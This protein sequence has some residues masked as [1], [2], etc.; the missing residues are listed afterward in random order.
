[1]AT[2]LSPAFPRRQSLRSA[3]AAHILLAQ[4]GVESSMRFATTAVRVRRQVAVAAHR[5]LRKSKVD[6]LILFLYR[7]VAAMA[8]TGT[9]DPKGLDNVDAYVLSEATAARVSLALPPSSAPPEARSAPPTGAAYRVV[10]AGAGFDRRVDWRALAAGGTSGGEGAP[11]WGGY[12]PDADAANAAWAAGGGIAGGPIMPHGGSWMGVPWVPIPRAPPAA[13]VSGQ[14]GSPVLEGGTKVSPATAYVAYVDSDEDSLDNADAVAMNGVGGITA[15]QAEREAAA[16]GSN[17]PSRWRLRLAPFRRPSFSAFVTYWNSLPL[18]R[19]ARLTSL[20]SVMVA[21]FLFAIALTVLLSTYARSLRKPVVKVSLESA[22]SLELPVI[23]ICSSFRE[24]PAFAAY[25]TDR[26]PGHP[27]FTA[28]AFVHWEDGYQEAYPNTL[29][30]G[31]VEEITTGSAA[32]PFSTCAERLSAMSLKRVLDNYDGFNGLKPLPGV[33]PLA[34][35]RCTACMRIGAGA[36]S[37]LAS[38]GGRMSLSANR[39]AAGLPIGISLSLTTS[40]AFQF[41]VDG[42][43]R[44]SQDTG[45]IFPH[46]LAAMTESILE[47]IDDITAQGILDFGDRDPFERNLEGERKWFSLTYGGFSSDDADFE[48]LVSMHCNVYFFSGY[49]YPLEEGLASVRFKLQDTG[50]ES[51]RPEGRVRWVADNAGSEALKLIKTDGYTT[52]F[53][54]V[55]SIS[56]LAPLPNLPPLPAASGTNTSTT[57]ADGARDTGRDTDRDAGATG[58]SESIEEI[59]ATR[60]NIT[61]A[62]RHQ[63][64]SRSALH[65]NL[66]TQSEAEAAAGPP[67]ADRQVTLVSQEDRYVR[68]ELS[69]LIDFDGSTRYLPMRVSVSELSRS[70]ISVFKSNMF[71]EWLFDI[72]YG[73]FVTTV[74]SV[75]AGVTP[76]Q[77]AADAANYLGAC[78]GASMFTFLIVP[79]NLIVAYAQRWS[80]TSGGLPPRGGAAG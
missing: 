35:P 40:D 54:D 3:A 71:N 49:F 80:R 27:I 12:R 41:C 17:P 77:V 74:N 38:S 78:T 22:A 47:H 18:Q 34:D 31:V 43:M 68:M 24:V 30:S 50:A 7:N 9:D 6:E 25:P 59:L 23:S 20:F 8:S 14:S 5:G 75:V 63:F 11:T 66:Y 72:S 46:S 16:F 73:S 15:C 13:T 19:Q 29:S 42:R 76:A 61:N 69:R 21:M 37:T 4:S 32:A 45:F 48:Q 56:V 64:A 53:N 44:R 28:R 51:N 70:K 60:K 26:Y 65:L 57:D 62:F 33:D 67:V 36:T 2:A 10:A 58:G 39:A 1:M 52:N 79:L 55:P